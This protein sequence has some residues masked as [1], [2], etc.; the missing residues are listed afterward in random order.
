MARRFAT[1]ESI[2]RKTPIFITCERFARIASN[3]RFALF[4]PPKRNSQKEVQFGNPGTIRENQAIRANLRI[5]SG[6]SGHLRSKSSTTKS[7]KMSQNPFLPLLGTILPEPRHVRPIQCLPVT[8]KHREMCV[9]CAHT[10]R[11]RLVDVWAPVCSHVKHCS[12]LDLPDGLVQLLDGLGI[13]SML[14]FGCKNR[15]ETKG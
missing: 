4:S 5:D 14:L 10:K 13:L 2:R 7:P 6:E 1:R 3:L 12:L 9:V 8:H 11:L 15:G